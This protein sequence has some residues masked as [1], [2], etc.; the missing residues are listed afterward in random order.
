M[1]ALKAFLWPFVRS[2]CCLGGKGGRQKGE[3][4]F[5]TKA[6]KEAFLWPLLSSLAPPK[7]TGVTSFLL[8]T[9]I[10]YVGTII[11]YKERRDTD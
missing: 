10:R 1:R 2:C 3:F 6:K 7:R 11:Q 4:F 5:V 9:S 8:P